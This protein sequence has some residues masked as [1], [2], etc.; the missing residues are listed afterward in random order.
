[1]LVGDL[2][3]IGHGINVAG[4]TGF[5]LERY[6][7]KPPIFYCSTFDGGNLHVFVRHLQ[8]QYSSPQSKGLPTTEEE[9]LSLIIAVM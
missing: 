3:I 8:S 2:V 6:V 7:R 4:I 9:W 5:P 1:M